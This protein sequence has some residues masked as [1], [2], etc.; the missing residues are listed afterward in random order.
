MLVVS[1][2]HQNNQTGAVNNQLSDVGGGG[3]DRVFRVTVNLLIRYRGIGAKRCS[4]NSTGTQTNS[5]MG[6][7]YAAKPIILSIQKASNGT[8]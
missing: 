4:K 3:G 1:D 2:S 8:D 7:K 6:S 5:K